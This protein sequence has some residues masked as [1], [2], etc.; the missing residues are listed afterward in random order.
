MRKRNEQFLT[1]IF[2]RLKKVLTMKVNVFLILIL[3][4]SP[5]L[6]YANSNNERDCKGFVQKELA[7]IPGWCSSRKA[8]AMIELIFKVK[9]AVCVELGVFAGASLFPTAMALKYVNH[10]VVY[11]IDSWNVEDSVRYYPEES[12][13]RIWWQ[14]QNMVVFHN[15]C[16]NLLARFD[17]EHSC[18]LI[19]ESFSQA[20][21]HFNSIDILHIDGSHTSEGDYLDA[22]AYCEKVSAEGYIWFDGWATSSQ[23]YE[24]LKKDFQVRKVINSGQ[25]ILL[26][27]IVK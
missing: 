4:F 10:G 26:Q 6:T 22:L 17:L 1:N 25:C 8:D 11:G 24:Y 18:V 9:P 2:L 21:D 27:R 3:F 5:A 15:Y 19:N 12:P 20:V 7:T 13:H 23:L 16:A 14:Q